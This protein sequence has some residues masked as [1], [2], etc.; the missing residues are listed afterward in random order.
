[1]TRVFEL[2]F[3][4]AC[5]LH[6]EIPQPHPPSD[7]QCIPYLAGGSD[8]KL[9]GQPAIIVQKTTRAGGNPRAGCLAE[10]TEEAHALIV[11][12]AL[13]IWQAMTV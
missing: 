10:Y 4:V 5:M 11:W 2:K 13:E 9:Q 6:P 3:I 1:M 12:E 8:R 7:V